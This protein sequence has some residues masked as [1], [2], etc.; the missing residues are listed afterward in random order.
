MAPIITGTIVPVIIIIIIIIR[1]PERTRLLGISRNGWEDNIVVGLQEIGWDGVY[2][3]YVT[4]DS[5]SVRLW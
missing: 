1:K 3:I 5:D 4:E 2:C